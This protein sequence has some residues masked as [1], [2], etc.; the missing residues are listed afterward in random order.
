MFPL[1]AQAK[2]TNRAG[3]TAK[4]A[5]AIEAALRADPNDLHGIAQ[6]FERSVGT[7]WRIGQRRHI[8]RGPQPAANGIDGA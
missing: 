7:I 8:L 4:E 2:R 5:D 6:R 3:I 1:G